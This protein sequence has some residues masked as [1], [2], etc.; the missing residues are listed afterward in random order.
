MQKDSENFGFAELSEAQTRQYIDAEA[1]WRALQ[2]AERAA[3]EVRGSMMWRAQDGRRYLIRV[4]ASGAQTSMGPESEHNTDIYERFMARKAAAQSRQRQ[5]RLA[6]QQHVRLNR[7]L[8]VGRVPNVVV[9]T[10]NALAQAGLEDHFVTV[11]THALYAYETACGV[12]VQTEAT[13]TQDIDLLLDTRKRLRFATTMQRLDSSLLGIFQKADKTFMLR[14]DQKY[15]AVNASG[16]EIDV[17]RRP[18]HS[19][20]GTDPHPLRVSKFEEDFWAVQIPSGQALLD[21][22]RFSHMVVAT[23]GQMAT[24]HAPMPHRF[25]HVKNQL[26]SRPDRDPLK[27]RKDDLQAR[28]VQQLLDQYGL[29]YIVQARQTRSDTGAT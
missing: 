13:A 28:V 20:A 5:L 4:A 9:E 23:S 11:G 10:L 3:K 24:L 6:V 27:A 17:V 25:I 12:R 8:R 2:S 26:A 22:G 18:A 7:A 21:S 29:S 1:A 14:D 16:F 15:T 19:R